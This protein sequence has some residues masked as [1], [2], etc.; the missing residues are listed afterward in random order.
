VTLILI[1]SYYSLNSSLREIFDFIISMGKIHNKKTMPTCGSI[2]D[3]FYFP[4]LV[5]S[6]LFKIATSKD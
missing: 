5:L 2:S 3:N 1:I 4:N 6:I